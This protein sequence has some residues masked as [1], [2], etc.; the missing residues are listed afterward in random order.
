MES[1]T[2][3]ARCSWRT[4]V[5]YE[6]PVQQPQPV[7]DRVVDEADVVDP[8]KW[9][10]IGAEDAGA[11]AVAA[12]DDGVALQELHNRR[13]CPGVGQHTPQDEHVAATNPED[14]ESAQPVDRAR[15]REVHDRGIQASRSQLCDIS[16]Q[17]LLAVPTR[18]TVESIGDERRAPAR[19]GKPSQVVVLRSQSE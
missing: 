15:H 8:G 4:D 5:R 9:S 19:A 7:R 13:V 10:K 2:A 3:D 6:G 17:A 14:V 12:V 16:A 1:Q 11:G 18:G